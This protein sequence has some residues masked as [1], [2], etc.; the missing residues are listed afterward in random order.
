MYV[1]DFLQ[2]AVVTVLSSRAKI[3]PQKIDLISTPGA[4][5]VCHGDS[6][7]VLVKSMNDK[8]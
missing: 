4:N 7:F 1:L 6:N 3:K 5:K 8:H 2:V